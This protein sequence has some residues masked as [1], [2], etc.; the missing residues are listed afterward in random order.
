MAGLDE[1]PGEPRQGEHSQAV[2]TTT[3][4]TDGIAPEHSLNE[5]GSLGLSR[6]KQLLKYIYKP[7]I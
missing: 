6:Q 7:F 1:C 3:Y 5:I 4:I 2:T